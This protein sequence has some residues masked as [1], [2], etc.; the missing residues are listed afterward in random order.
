[1]K[2]VISAADVLGYEQFGFTNC[3]RYK[4]VFYLSGIASLDVQGRVIG[5]DIEA[6]TAKTFENIERILRAGGS[7]LDQILQM[8]S[9]VVGLES[10]GARYVAARKRMLTAHNYTSAVIGV[11][12]LMMAGLLVEVQCCAAVPD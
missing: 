3:V 12:A 6:Q 1:M 10:N 8:T 7:S 9:F 5:Q 4:D 2:Q 11:S